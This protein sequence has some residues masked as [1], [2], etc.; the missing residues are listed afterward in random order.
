MVSYPPISCICCQNHE[1]AQGNTNEIQ[2]PIKTPMWRNFIFWSYLRVKLQTFS[3]KNC[4]NSEQ[5]IKNLLHTML[6]I[7][8]I[9]LATFPSS[10]RKKLFLNIKNIFCNYLDKTILFYIPPA[11]NFL[12]LSSSRVKQ[13]DCL[14]F[15]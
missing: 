14:R 12:V 5:T 1:N 9:F 7:L 8:E 4:K 10:F 11:L 3:G 2:I 15:C 13:E 6:I